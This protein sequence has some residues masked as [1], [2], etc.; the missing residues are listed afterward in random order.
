MWGR[1]LVPGDVPSRMHGVAV[2]RPTN[3]LRV[4]SASAPIVRNVTLSPP[5]RSDH[6]G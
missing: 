2:T 1:E 4:D 3:S 6:I 5:H